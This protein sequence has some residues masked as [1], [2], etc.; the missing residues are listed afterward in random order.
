M[1]RNDCASIC[2]PGQYKPQEQYFQLYWREFVPRRRDNLFNQKGKLDSQQTVHLREIVPCD[3]EKT[4]FRFHPATYAFTHQDTSEKKV[5][6]GLL[7]TISLSISHRRSQSCFGSFKMTSAPLF[8]PEMFS[9]KTAPHTT[10]LAR[11]LLRSWSQIQ[12]GALPNRPRI[13]SFQSRDIQRSY[14]SCIR[15]HKE[16]NFSLSASLNKIF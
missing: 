1:R 14:V 4:V 12:G 10:R 15:M 11:L 3:K 2:Q 13:F 9:L 6:Y 16:F 8:F 7:D 5:R